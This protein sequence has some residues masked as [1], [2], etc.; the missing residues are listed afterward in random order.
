MLRSEVY[1]STSV[2]QKDLRVRLPKSAVENLDLTPG[3]T[4][5]EILFDVENRCIVLKPASK[6]DEPQL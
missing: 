1:L 3:V 5:L 2:L 4:E 6:T